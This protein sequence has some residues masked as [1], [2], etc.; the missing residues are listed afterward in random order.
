MSAFV[1]VDARVRVGTPLHG[2]NLFP[3]VPGFRDAVLD[4]M[5]ELTGLGHHLI[6]AIGRGL[7]LILTLFIEATFQKVVNTA[8]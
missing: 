3:Q 7:R 1:D 6:S 8:P 5:T 4:Y 2:G